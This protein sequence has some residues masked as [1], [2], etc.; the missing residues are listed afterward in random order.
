MDSAIGRPVAPDRAAVEASSN[1]E[2]IKV[3]A[4]GTGPG[5]A[6]PDF[7]ATNLRFG[8][9]GGMAGGGIDGSIVSDALRVKGAE[10]FDC[11]SIRPAAVRIETKRRWRMRCWV[12]RSQGSAGHVMNI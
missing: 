11:W 10:G 8:G 2:G 5:C 9:V 7:F 6:D 1:G 4:F 12:G 3:G